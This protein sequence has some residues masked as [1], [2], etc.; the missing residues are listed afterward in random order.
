MWRLTNDD[1]AREAI[2][3]FFPSVDA[4][5]VDMVPTTG[6]VNNIVQYLTF[7][8]GSKKLL[9]IY[10]NGEDTQQVTFEHAVLSTLWEE[11]YADKFDFKIPKYMPF[12][13]SGNTF[14]KLSNGAEA[15]IVDFIDGSLPKISCL[16][17]IGKASGELCTALGKI[18]DIVKNKAECNC[19]PYYEMWE[20]HTAITKENFIATM[21]GPDFD[22]KLRPFADLML[23]ETIKITEKC[24][25]DYKDLPEQLLHGDLHYDNVLVKDGAVTGLLDFEFALFDWRAM[26]LATCLSKY[27]GEANGMELFEEFVKGYAITGELT[28]KEAEAIPD[29]IN[30]RVLSN[31]VYFVGRAIAKEDKIDSLTKRIEN[32]SERVKWIQD[33]EKTIIDIIKKYYPSG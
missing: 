14:A 9:R 6:G 33:N 31:V 30:L 17:P 7:P 19:D 24:E 11:G 26:E 32:Y 18:T 10:N 22:G 23:D 13:D 3:K 27:A 16:E 21:K 12:G 25:G 20:I 2:N 1:L 4:K 29:L 5:A 15:C 8:D 28:H